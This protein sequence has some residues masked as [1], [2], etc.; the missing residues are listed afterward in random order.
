MPQCKK[1][2]AKQHCGGAAAML[3]MT[4][5]MAT[6]AW[7]SFCNAAQIFQGTMQANSNNNSCTAAG[8]VTTTITKSRN[9]NLCI[10]CFCALPLLLLLQKGR[11]M[12]CADAIKLIARALNPAALRALQYRD[13]ARSGVPRGAMH[14]VFVCALNWFGLVCLLVGYIACCT[15]VSC[16]N[17]SKTATATATATMLWNV[18]SIAKYLDAFAQRSKTR[19]IY[20][21]SMWARCVKFPFFQPEWGILSIGFA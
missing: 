7:A 4:M 1:Q 21:E 11:I 18:L 12:K 5:A 16:Y 15:I 20:K 14:V 17:N 10:H 13:A 8:T 2:N 3:A 6:G 19:R 9:T